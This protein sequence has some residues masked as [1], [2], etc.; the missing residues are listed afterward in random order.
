VDGCH[1]PLRRNQLRSLVEV[2]A[3]VVAAEVVAA[4]VDL[5]PSPAVRR[6]TPDAVG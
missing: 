3:E 5:P 1:A 2:A 6:I 4:E